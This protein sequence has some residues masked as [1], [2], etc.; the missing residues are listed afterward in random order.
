MVPAANGDVFFVEN[1]GGVTD[2]DSVQRNADECTAF[3]RVAEDFHLRNFSELLQCILRNLFF[4]LA[5]VVEADVVQPFDGFSEAD[6]FGN[7]GRACFKACWDVGIGCLF[8]R[9][10]LDHFATAVPRRHAV[11]YIVLAVKNADSGRAVH[12]VAAEREKVAVELLYV[13]FDVA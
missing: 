13:N 3:F 12:F 2:G 6:D 5:D 10:V 8:E 4:V 11:E 7:G 9:D 1:H